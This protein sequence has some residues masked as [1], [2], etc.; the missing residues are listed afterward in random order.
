MV[1]KATGS[2]VAGQ[3]A[4]FVSGLGIGILSYKSLSVLDHRFNFSGLYSKVGL[5]KVYS[6][7][8][9]REEVLSH[10]NQDDWEMM[11]L[12]ERK[13]TC[14]QLADIISDELGLKNRPS[15]K[16]YYSDSDSCYGAFEY[17]SNRLKINTYYFE[18]GHTVPWTEIVDTIAHELRHAHQF[19]NLL[20]DPNSDISRSFINYTSSS[21]SFADYWMQPCE[22]DARAYAKQWTEYQ[23]LSELKRNPNVKKPAPE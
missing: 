11:S 12:A 6:N 20:V 17:N 3:W 19:A 2:D 13:A 9:R 8:V 23:L 16:Y 22:V 21:E 18:K 14:N 10:F 7:T 4:G 15:I 5:G 1:I